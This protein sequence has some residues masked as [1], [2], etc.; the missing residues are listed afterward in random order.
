MRERLD[1]IRLKEED[2]IENSKATVEVFIA[3]GVREA[4]ATILTRPMALA[5]HRTA[6][7]VELKLGREHVMATMETR[8]EGDV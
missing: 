5:V 1:V 7:F 4:T 2:P 6:N 8:V 3:R